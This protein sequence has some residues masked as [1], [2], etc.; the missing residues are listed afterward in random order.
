MAVYVDNRDVLLEEIRKASQER[1]AAMEREHEQRI[2]SL[3]HDA[4]QRTQQELERLRAKH[5]KELER[6]ERQ[7]KGSHE[8]ALRQ[9]LIAAQGE[10]HA[11]VIARAKEL[12][13]Q[14]AAARNGVIGSMVQALAHDT[15]IREF[16]VPRNVTIGRHDCHAVLDEM[17]V[18]GIVGEGE[19]VELTLDDLLRQ[20]SAQV[21]KTIA[22]GLF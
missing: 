7:R 21:Y 20:H 14:D 11:R 12:L 18:I 1:I 10:V 5:Q 15:R 6:A 2:L 8:L 4:D 17:K 3:R 13:L 16:R 22:T 19:E 9:Q